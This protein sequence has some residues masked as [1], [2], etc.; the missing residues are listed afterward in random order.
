MDDNLQPPKAAVNKAAS[1]STY[2]PAKTQIEVIPCKI[3]GDKSSGVHYGVITCEGC[4]GFFRRSQSGPVNYQCPR[5]KQCV[6]DRVNRNRCQYCRLQ[7]CL[8]LGMSRD[9]VKFGRMSKKQREKVEGE[10]QLIKAGVQP[11]VNGYAHT[12]LPSPNNNSHFTYN[13]DNYVYS[14]NGYVYGAGE[15]TSPV[16][17]PANAY[18]PTATPPTPVVLRTVD[19]LDNVAFGKAILEAHQRTSPYSVE[20]IAQL[21]ATPVS[22]ELITL[23]QNMTHRQV[24]AEVADKLT[25]AVQQIIEFA[26]MVPG[27]MDLSQDDQIMLLK[28]GSFE[29][30]LLRCTTAYDGTTDSVIFGDRFVP[31]K[32]FSNLTEEEVLLQNQIFDLVKTIQ[33]ISLTEGEIALF[34]ATLLVRPDRPGLKDL[35]DIQKLYEKI[36][37]ALKL[38]LGKNNREDENMITKLNQ[39]TWIVRN[40]NTQHIN[41]LNKFKQAEP[42]VEFPALHK[43]LFSVEG[44]DNS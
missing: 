18:S 22:S 27:F 13:T 21:K 12:E 26:K 25:F 41:V 10:A 44:Q 32:A 2:T 15:S 23:Y 43:E 8:A 35:T 33:H 14:P 20:T 5:N 42:D 11:G 17:P 16:S 30:A 19:L 38:E 24:W 34:S 7:K 36:T 1:S 29:L 39:I 40:L 6:I 9:A 3:C 37:S 28:A 4:K 31:L